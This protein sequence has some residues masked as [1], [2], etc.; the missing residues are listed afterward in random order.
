MKTI[1]GMTYPEISE[2]TG[3]NEQTLKNR[4]FRARKELAHTL[5]RMGVNEL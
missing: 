2:I 1:D 4:M 5:K 3:V